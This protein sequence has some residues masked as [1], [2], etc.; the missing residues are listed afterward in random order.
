MTKRDRI[1]GTFKLILSRI[2]C[3]FEKTIGVIFSKVKTPRSPREQAMIQILDLAK[4][5]I[6]AITGKVF[7]WLLASFSAKC[8]DR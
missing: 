5:R 2:F 4:A 1:A 6:T 7:V 8:L 3:F